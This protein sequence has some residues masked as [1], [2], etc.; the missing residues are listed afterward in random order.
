[1]I[2]TCGWDS[3]PSGGRVLPIPGGPLKSPVQLWK[4]TEVRA[5]LPRT[6]IHFLYGGAWESEST[7]DSY[8]QPRF[9]TMGVDIG[10]MSCYCLTIL[11]LFPME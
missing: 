11:L 8:V 10:G 9:K 2:Q 5:P 4:N 7:A 3:W 6:F 1:M